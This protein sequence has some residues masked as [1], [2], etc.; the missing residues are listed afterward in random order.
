[1][2]FDFIYLPSVKKPLTSGPLTSAITTVNP[3]NSDLYFDTG[4][5]AACTFVINFSDDM[6]YSF[7]CI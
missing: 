1:M 5:L 3:V 7:S 2:K 4:I 6:I